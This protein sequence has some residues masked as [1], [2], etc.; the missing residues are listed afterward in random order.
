ML[1][2][3]ECCIVDAV[4][5]ILGAFEDDGARLIDAARQEARAEIL[6][7]DAGRQRLGEVARGILEKFEREQL[8]K[9]YCEFLKEM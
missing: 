9:G 8:V 6:G 5:V 7:D 2:D 4:V 1:V 3:A